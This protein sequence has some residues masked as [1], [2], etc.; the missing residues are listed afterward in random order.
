V[1]GLAS[2]LNFKH[3][4]YYPF[5]VS[6]NCHDGTVENEVLS[7]ICIWKSIKRSY[8]NLT[9]HIFSIRLH[10]RYKLR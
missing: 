7:E 2:M 5:D 9:F 4:L 6:N 8:L 1:E 3:S 10:K